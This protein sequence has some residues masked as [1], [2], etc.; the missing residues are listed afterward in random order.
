MANGRYI[1]INYPFRNSPKG[2]FLDLTTTDNQAI[3]SDLMHLILTRKGQR[4]YNPDFGT[5]LLQFI[6]EPNDDLTF[7]SIKQEITDVVKRYLPNLQI[8]EISV[9]ESTESEYAAVLRIDY[10]ITDD[11]FTTTDF[12][13]INI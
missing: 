2:F 3:K 9:T 13:I 8:N 10:S 5:N 4:L 6:F 7:S 1:N 11:V 12:I